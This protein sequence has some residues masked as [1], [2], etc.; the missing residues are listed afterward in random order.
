VSAMLELK[1]FAGQNWVITPAALAAN[2]TAPANIH[3]QKWLLILSGVA[4]ANIR[5]TDFNEVPDIKDV[6]FRP[7]I[8]N[9]CNYAIN[10]YGIPRPPGVEN[11]NYLVQFQVEVWAPFAGVSG[12]LNRDSDYAEIEVAS[13]RPTHF[14]NGFDMFTGNPL[15]NIFDGL[16]VSCVVADTDAELLRI[17]YNISLLGKI[18]FTQIRITC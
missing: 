12:S 17:G 13:W 10:Q 18:V 1:T 11:Q 6:Q 16:V 9:P 4:Y 3:D 15:G 7:N 14:L 2:Q 8:V 5:G